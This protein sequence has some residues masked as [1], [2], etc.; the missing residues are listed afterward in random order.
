MFCI[1]GPDMWEPQ[2]QVFFFLFFNGGSF[3][4]LRRRHADGAQKTDK[5]RKQD[6]GSPRGFRERVG[7]LLVFG[8]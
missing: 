4:H 2:K 8:L 5:N 6:S 7:V 1:S 3:A